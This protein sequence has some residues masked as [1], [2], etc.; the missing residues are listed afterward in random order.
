MP[1]RVERRLRHAGWR[2]LLT[3]RRGEHRSAFVWRQPAEGDSPSGRRRALGSRAAGAPQ[4]RHGGSVTAVCMDQVSTTTSRRPV[5]Y[6]HSHMT[7]GLRRCQLS[8]FDD[9]L[10]ISR[11]WPLGTGKTCVERPCSVAASHLLNSRPVPIDYLTA[12]TSDIQ[13]VRPRLDQTVR[14]VLP[15][16]PSSDSGSRS[17]L[18]LHGGP[19]LR[20]ICLLMKC[21]TRVMADVAMLK[22][23]S[24]S[25]FHLPQP[26]VGRIILNNTQYR[27]SI[28]D[29]MNYYRRFCI[30]IYLGLLLVLYHTQS[31]STII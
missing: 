18:F 25:D 1:Q 9:C 29:K 21:W 10:D 4:G 24:T 16:G 27:P 23:V 7:D 14:S 15:R 5:P 17:M 30:Y 8:F 31:R 3:S 6:S 19:V 26:C 12:V 13:L 28:S 2:V 20:P 11:N 22:W